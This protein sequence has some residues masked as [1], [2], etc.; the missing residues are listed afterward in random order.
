[1]IPDSG[2]HLKLMFSDFWS[3]LLHSAATAVWSPTTRSKN[4]STSNQQLSSLFK[5]VWTASWLGPFEGTNSSLPS[6][7]PTIRTDNKHQSPQSHP[8]FRV[9]KHQSI[10]VSHFGQKSWTRLRFPF[11]LPWERFEHCKYYS[12]K[13]HIYLFIYLFI[14]FV[15]IVNL[16]VEIF[17]VSQLHVKSAHCCLR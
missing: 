11:H 4:S 17:V 7:S 16:A 14:Y 10:L 1:M 5:V 9:T 3:K 15:H 6:A 13:F 12:I 2:F 8:W